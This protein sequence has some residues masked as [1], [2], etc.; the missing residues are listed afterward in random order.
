MKDPEGFWLEAAAALKC[1]VAPRKALDDS[2]TPFYR[3]FPDASLRAVRVE[4][5]GRDLHPRDRR[6]PLRTLGHH[7]QEISKGE[8]RR[9]SVSHPHSIVGSDRAVD[10]IDRGRPGRHRPDSVTERDRLPR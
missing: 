5:L 8:P 3:W 10:A 1:E 7:A 6:A 9:R 4:M 2:N